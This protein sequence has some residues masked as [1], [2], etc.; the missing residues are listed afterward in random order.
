M[1]INNFKNEKRSYE[2]TNSRN[3]MKMQE[4]IIFVYQR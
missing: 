4:S 2:Q 1:K 3:H